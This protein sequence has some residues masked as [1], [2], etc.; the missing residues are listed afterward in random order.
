MNAEYAYEMIDRFLRNNL[1][2][3]D[4]AEYSEALDAIYAP[5]K[6]EPVQEPVA[7]VRTFTNGAGR[8]EQR[9]VVFGDVNEGDLLYTHPQPKAEIVPCNLAPDGVD[10]YTFNLNVRSAPTHP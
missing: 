6:S 8:R 3:D 10:G 2:D 7:D 4:Y 9:V 1:D 5:S